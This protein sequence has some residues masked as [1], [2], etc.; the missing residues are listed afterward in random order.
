M[1]FLRGTEHGEVQIFDARF[2][3]TTALRC[4]RRTGYI[5][6][7]GAS[8]QVYNANGQG[9][10]CIERLKAF[11][12]AVDI[13]GTW[14]GTGDVDGSVRVVK[15]TRDFKV[16]GTESAIVDAATCGAVMTAEMSDCGRWFMTSSSGDGL[17]RV[18]ETRTGKLKYCQWASPCVALS[19]DGERLATEEGP[20]IRVRRSWHSL[21]DADVLTL[22]PPET[23]MIEMA[24]GRDATLLVV[25]EDGLMI[26]HEA[27]GQVRWSKSIRENWL[28]ELRLSPD[29][30][31][32]ALGDYDGGLTM[33]AMR[34]GDVLAQA[35]WGKTRDGGNRGPI[36]ALDWLSDTRIAA[37]SVADEAVWIVSIER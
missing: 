35:S 28:T 32:V 15:L 13:E 20:A 4:A 21:R 5:F 18:W 37:L 16:E 8:L 33:L 11:S 34:S 9:G 24:V 27:N 6:V 7:G 17:C 1:R 19:R 3:K 23:R 2:A 22:V 25:Y 31:V 36:Y 14:L 26:C 10:C 30:S 29:E 12:I